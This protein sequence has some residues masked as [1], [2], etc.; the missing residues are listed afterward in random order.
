[1]SQAI[2][3]VAKKVRP[4]VMKCGRVKARYKRIKSASHKG[5]RL[6]LGW[7]FLKR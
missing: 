2:R 5:M 6:G 3:N 1:M 7:R 4:M